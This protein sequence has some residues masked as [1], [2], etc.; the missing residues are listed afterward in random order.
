MSKWAEDE[1][2]NNAAMHL[3]QDAIDRLDNQLPFRS[4]QRALPIGYAQAHRA[5]L[6]SFASHGEPP[7]PSVIGEVSGADPAD[8]REML[9]D[10]DLVVAADGRITGA[11]PFTLESTPHL[12]EFGDVQVNAMCALDAVAVAPVLGLVVVTSSE[13][14]VTGTPIR[15]RQREDAVETVEPHGLRIGLRWQQP[16]GC[17]A[18]STCREMVFLSDAAVAE[19]WRGP[20]PDSAAIF[21]LTQAIAVGVGFFGP[22]LDE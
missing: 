3:I 17:A 5:I 13:C 18:H 22:L 9:A 16:D 10:A 7:D 15:I 6:R 21:D 1:P 8:V 12:I 19:E 14:V 2:W 11:Y 4:R 20:E